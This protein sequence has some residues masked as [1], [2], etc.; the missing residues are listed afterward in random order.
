VGAGRHAAPEFSST[1]R[2]DGSAG[3]PGD[4]AA[5]IARAQRQLARVPG[6]WPTWAELGLAYVQQARLTSDPSYYPKA[7]GALHRS[8]AEHPSGNHLALIG[9]GA[10]AAARH[11]FA[12]AL[13]YG[14]QALA[15]DPYS[16]PAQGVVADAL[17]EL[18]RYPQAW[19]AIQRMVDLRPDTGSLARGSYAAELRGDLGR[20][21]QLLE[22]ALRLA[23]SAADAGYVLYYL[24]ELAWNT[25]DLARARGRWEEGLRRAPAYLP[26]L[27][28]RARIAAA[29]GRYGAAVAAY[30]I[31]VGRLPQPGYLSEYAD[32]L[33]AHGDRRGATAQYAVVRA[34]ERLFA[35]QGV[36]V[37]LEL[38]LFDA[39]HGAAARA[40]TEARA[41]YRLRQG[42][43]AED[44]LAWALHANGRDAEAL[45]HARAA[46][47]QGTRNAAFRY[48]LGMIE[49]ALGDRAAARRN[50]AEALRLN[51]HFSWLQAPRARTA[52]AALGGVR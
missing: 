17:V 12:A 16:A 48:H 21:R 35:A 19:A 32:L 10:L 13:R 33:A 34:E 1:G 51:P 8:L 45:P 29:D 28:G 50:L 36:N 43:L 41:T 15:I 23:P 14:E 52:L 11:D 26:L 6:D 25:G 44:A 40:L 49:L 46:L 3:L 42:V 5:G 30:R 7:G 31:V 37:D 20:A 38:A 4:L 18:G 2:P 47:A 24:G 9:L 22:A 27:V 39:D